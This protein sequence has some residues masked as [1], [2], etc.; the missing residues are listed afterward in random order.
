[1]VF[2]QRIIDKNVCWNQKMQ[3]ALQKHQSFFIKYE[4][5][6]GKSIQSQGVPECAAVRADDILNC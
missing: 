5:A 6:L 3:Y 2:D 4:A 1:M